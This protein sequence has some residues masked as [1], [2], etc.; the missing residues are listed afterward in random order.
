MCRIFTS[1]DPAVTESETRAIRLHGHATSVRLEAAFWTILEEIAAA[2]GMALVRFLTVLH[3]EMALRH[4]EV[5]NFASMLRVT[6]LQYLRYQT[7]HANEVAMRR[8]GKRH[9][10]ETA[11]NRAVLA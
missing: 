2:E 5:T 3:D 10:F 7:L 4:G 6:C 8:E 1:V 11:E 9:G